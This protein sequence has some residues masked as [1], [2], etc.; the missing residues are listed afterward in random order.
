MVESTKVNAELKKQVEYYLSDKNLSTDKFFNEKLSESKDGWLD[1]THILACNK[2]K[3]MKV[4]AADIV[5]SIK[6]SKEVEADGEGKKIR[7]KGGKAIP[8][9]APSKRRD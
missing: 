3:S 7:R 4:T 6:D 2:I 1:L 5:A 8:S 9:L